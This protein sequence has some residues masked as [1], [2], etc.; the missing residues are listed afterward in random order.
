M[1]E[2]HTSGVA[3]FRQDWL[4]YYTYEKREATPTVVLPNGRPTAIGKLNRYMRV[5]PALTALADMRPG[6]TPSRSAIVVDGVAPN[7]DI[8][9][10][11]AWAAFVD[12]RDLLSKIFE[13]QARWRPL[14]VGI[15]RVAYQK[16]L[17]Y[18]IEERAATKGKYIRIVELIPDTKQSKEARIRTAIAESFGEQKVYVRKD[19]TEFLEEYRL[20]PQTGAQRDLLDAFAYGPQMWRTPIGDDDEI[21]DDGIREVVNLQ[22]GRSPITGY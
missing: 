18:W 13:L 6:S 7:G 1:C 20:F 12:P 22:E 3:E 15:E 17:K 21:E 16:V 5:D 9:L 8:Y 2:P 14:A 4:Q 11:D 19:Q 10:L